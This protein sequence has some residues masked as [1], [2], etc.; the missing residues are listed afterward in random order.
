MEGSVLAA[1]ADQQNRATHSTNWH[2]GVLQQEAQN[3]GQI[4]AA[5][6]ISIL[7]LFLVYAIFQKQFVQGA[8]FSGL[9]M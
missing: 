5:A 4:L 9:K 7:P 2:Y 3:Q 1:A 8:S 6:I